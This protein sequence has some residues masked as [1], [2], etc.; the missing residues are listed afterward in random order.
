MILKVIVIIWLVSLILTW[1]YMHI[2]YSKGGVLHIVVPDIW[3]VLVVTIPLINTVMCMVL[4]VGQNPR[5]GLNLFHF[6]GK[7][8]NKLSNYDIIKMFFLIRD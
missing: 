1:L 2:A 8:L 6:L 5:T 4:W 3:D 7:Y